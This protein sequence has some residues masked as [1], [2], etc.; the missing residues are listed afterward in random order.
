MKIQTAQIIAST[1]NVVCILFTFLIAI[2][3]FRKKN[4]KNAETRLYSS[5]LIINIIAVLV[6][7]VFYY[8]LQNG[9][10]S[11]LS[12]IVEKI[13]YL[14]TIMWM[15]LM[16]VYT[17]S[18][19]HI[20]S[21]TKISKWSYNE[22]RYGIILTFVI[23]A[24]ILAFLPITRQ[25]QDGIVASSSGAAPAAMFLL[26]AFLLIINFVVI[27]IKRKEIKIKKFLPMFLFFIL[28]LIQMILSSFGFQLLFITLNITLVSHLMYHTIENPDVKMIEQLNIAREQADKA[29]KAKTEFLSNMSH[30][31]RTPLNAIVG[32]SNLLLE[33][34]NIPDTSK[35]EVKDIIMASDNLLEIVNGILD[36]SKIEANKMEI[37]ASEYSFKKLA[38]ELVTLTKGRIAEKPLEFKVSIDETIPPVLYGDAQKVK[39]ICVNILTNAVKYTKEGWIELK[40]SH[41]IKNDICRLI[42]SVED[43]GIG[44]KEGNIERIFDKFDRLDTADNVTIE[45]T[46]LGL[47][48]TKKLLDMM[49]GKIVVQSTLGKGSK[50]TVSIDQKIVKNPTIKIEEDEKVTEKVEVRDEKL[51][52]IVDD[53][54]INLKVAERLLESYGIKSVSVDN[55]YDAIEKIKKGE[56][57]DLILMDD[58]MPKLSGTETFHE[59]EKIEGFNIPVIALTANALT[60]EREKYLSEGFNDYLAKPINKDE[61]N[62]IINKYLNQ[63]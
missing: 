40:I 32:F 44:I 18:I 4:V 56:K 26:C 21:K 45:G 16:T 33:D 22:K 2:C 52:L 19:T 7:P 57:Y 59:L 37:E 29:N 11:L 63:E 51:V 34:K 17:F 31:I 20:F 30:E 54:K 60:G 41:V 61:L 46:G 28:I 58:M 48:I 42:I 8:L 43:T 1:I 27:I 6:E 25:Y 47:A 62:N 55:G 53:N 13:Y 39:Q 12:N 35:D 14:T 50:F 23:F 3:F 10:E 5:L 15:Y 36:I 38:N 24:V 49:N 9:T